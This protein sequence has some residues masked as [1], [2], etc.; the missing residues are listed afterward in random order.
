MAHFTVSPGQRSTVS[1][2]PRSVT[3]LPFSSTTRCA[4]CSGEPI[5]SRTLNWKPWRCMGWGMLFSSLWISQTSLAPLWTTMGTSSILW[6]LPLMSHLHLL[7]MLRVLHMLRVLRMA[8]VSHVSH[9]VH[10]PA[11]LHLVLA[12]HRVE[13]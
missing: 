13:G 8:H 1:L 10:T 5:L 9:M 2:R 7:R 3:S 4:T 12:V 6:V 11:H